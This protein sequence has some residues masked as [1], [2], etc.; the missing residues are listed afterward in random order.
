[1]RGRTETGDGRLVTNWD[2]AALLYA[3]PSVASNRHRSSRVDYGH[4]I[5]DRGHRA[6]TAFSPGAR[7]ATPRR[8]S[9]FAFGSGAAENHCRSPTITFA[10]LSEHAQSPGHPRHQA[11]VARP[12]AHEAK[13]GYN[14]RHRYLLRTLP[15]KNHGRTSPEN[16]DTFPSVEPIH[17]PGHR[18]P[19][20]VRG[21]PG[22]GLLADLPGT[23]NALEH[24]LRAG[25]GFQLYDREQHTPPREHLSQ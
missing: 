3:V 17:P 11:W 1:M 2:R 13:L 5:P 10:T 8:R 15:S 25:C 22:R 16:K 7:V 6:T 20:R 23:T 9:F 19:G 12:A 18:Q 14:R 4:V 21:R 24:H